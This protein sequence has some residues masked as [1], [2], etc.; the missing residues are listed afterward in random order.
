MRKCF[1]FTSPYLRISQMKEYSTQTTCLGQINCIHSTIR[2]MY[3]LGFQKSQKITNGEL[4]WADILQCP[5]FDNYSPTHAKAFRNKTKFIT[6]SCVGFPLF[7]VSDFFLQFSFCRLQLIFYPSL[8]CLGF[9]HILEEVGEAYSTW[10]L[11][12]MQKT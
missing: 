1:M 5:R 4:W 10:K 3:F 11:F 6:Y 9:C 12:T 7:F 8:A 2:A